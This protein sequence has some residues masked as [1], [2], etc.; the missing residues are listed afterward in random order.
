MNKLYSFLI[1]LC[2][3]ASTS[4]AAEE[5]IGV[6][7]ETRVDRTGASFIGYY[8]KD[9]TDSIGIYALVNVGTDGYRQAYAGPKWK[10]LSWLEVGAGLGHENIPN[11]IRRNFFFDAN[12]EKVNVFGTFEN[13]GSGS[14]H[15]VTATYKLS[16]K[17]SAGIMNQ[18]GL[19]FGSRL[20]YGVTKT[21]QVWGAVLHEHGKTTPTIAI[22]Y[23]F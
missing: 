23:S 14:W 18:T 21:V 7:T 6:W 5:K 22:T 11:S 16:E 19:G 4:V 3:L 2:V 12:W 8:D 9:F 10:P 1:L 15:K 17:I 20:E 13:G